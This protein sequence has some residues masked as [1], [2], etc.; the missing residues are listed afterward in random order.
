MSEELENWL[1]GEKNPHLLSEVLSTGK[2][3]FPFPWQKGLCIAITVK[4]LEMGRLA[5]IIQAGPI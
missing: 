1:M 5:W 2:G 4:Y 3:F